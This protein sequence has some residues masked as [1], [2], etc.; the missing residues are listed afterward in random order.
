VIGDKGILG[1]QARTCCAWI[2][3]TSNQEQYVLSWGTAQA[4][5]CW[6][7][8]IESN[9]TLSTGVYAGYVN[10]TTKVNDGQ[11]HHI[12]VI[13]KDDGSPTAN[14]ILLYIDGTVQS[15]T[16]SSSQSVN[17]VASQDVMIGSILNAGALYKCYDGLL[18]EV[19]IYNRALEP[20]EINPESLPETGLVNH[21]TMDEAAGTVVHDSVSSYDGQLY[22]TTPVWAICEGTNYP[23]LTW[24]IPETD[25][26][27]PDGVY[28]EDLDYF[29]GQ[30]LLDNCTTSNNYCGG[31][32]INTSGKVD[33]EDWAIFAG[34]WLDGV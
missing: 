27:C 7:I 4:G 2:K 25:W 22:N 24:Q 28:T 18:D 6:G 31:V 12:A 10:T 19:C 17:T 8:R 34:W 9:G 33:L 21:W 16:A 20:N 29:V 1:T 30:W 5:Q 23:K 15:T 32:D 3:T 26:V 13:L 11:W 14:E